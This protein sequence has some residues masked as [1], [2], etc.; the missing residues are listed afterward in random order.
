MADLFKFAQPERLGSSLFSAD[1]IFPRLQDYRATLQERGLAGRPLFF[2]K[3]DVQ[4]CFDTIPQQPLLDLIEGLFSATEYSISRHAQAR[5]LAESRQPGLA[6]KAA[7]KFHSKAHAA[8]HDFDIP[9]MLEQGVVDARP[10]TVFVDSVVRKH[11]NRHHIMELLREHV[12]KNVVQIGRK[13]YRQKVGIPQGS[14]VSSL[15]CSFFYG[16]L[17]DKVLGF[18]RNGEA[19]LLRLIDDF[20]LITTSQE[21]ARRFMLVMHAGLPQ[22][23]LTVKT[24]KSR[25]NFDVSIRGELIPRIPDVADFPYCGIAI[26]TGN[27]NITKDKERKRTGSE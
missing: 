9:Q 13:F 19:L 4:S 23:G 6:P 27:L 8:S 22:Y 10:G 15:L 18:V 16:E 1:E 3:V 25:A 5:L 14:I 12:G 7:W 21:V 26:N 24:A 2:A 17:E 20:L 11:E